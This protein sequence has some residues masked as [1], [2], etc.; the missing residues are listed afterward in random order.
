M[1]YI[2]CCKCK[3]IPN[4]AR[5]A[6]E[7]ILKPRGINPPTAVTQENIYRILPKIPRNSEG[8][9]LVEKYISRPGKF[10]FFISLSDTGEIEET[11]DLLKGMK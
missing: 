1:N 5:S 6:A 11:I 3:E 8:Y 2:F 10:A 4:Y 9:R 7:I